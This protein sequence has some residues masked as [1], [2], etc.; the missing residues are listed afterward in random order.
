MSAATVIIIINGGRRT[1]SSQRDVE[2]ISALAEAFTKAVNNTLKLDDADEK[3][4]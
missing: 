4:D 2:V 3:N 1:Q